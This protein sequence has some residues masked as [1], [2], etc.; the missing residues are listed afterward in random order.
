MEALDQAF[1]L[2]RSRYVVGIDLGTTNCAMA[3][4]D[5][6]DQARRVQTMSI[7]QMIEFGM[8][9]HLDTLPSF[10]YELTESEA[11]SID[12]R[13]RFNTGAQSKEHPG[14]VGALARERSMQVPGRGIASAKSWLCNTQVDRNSDLLPWHGDEEV[15]RL[16]PVE[17]SSRYLLH[18]RRLWDRQHP[19]DPLSEQEVVVTLP[20]SFDEVA[21]QL[22]LEATRRAGLENVVLI[23]E[24]QAA[25]YAWLER[26]Q[27][28]WSETLRP[29][30]TILV[31]DIGGGTTDFTLIRVIDSAIALQA[32]ADASSSAAAQR[33]DASRNVEQKLQKTFGL[34]RVA[35]GPHLLLGG[36][37]LDLA[38][39]H[40]VEQQLAK[41]ANQQPLTPR[42]WDVLKAQ[43]RKAKETMLGA[44]PPDRVTIAL[45]GSGAKLI[46]STR[47]VTIERDW[48]KRL[49]VEGFFGQVPL[50]AVP[51]RGEVLFQEFGLPYESEPSVHK[52]LAQFLWEHRWAGRADS[53]RSNL[54]DRLAARPDWIL[55]NG[56]VLESKEIRDA[57]LLQIR[58][59]F[60]P[61]S[62]SDWSPGELEGN[63]LDL[64][65]AI[66]AAYF[67]LVRR[68]EGIR[69]DARLARTY[70]LQ[71]Q[72]SPPKAICIM[73]ASAM[74]L[75]RL[76]L[77]QHPFAL[78]IGEPV[79]FP[80]YCSST[81]L[82]HAFGEIIDVDLQWMTP[83]P[84][85]QT[86][87]ESGRGRKRETIPV[88]LECE[89]T[90]IGTLAMR[91][92][93]EQRQEGQERAPSWNLE[94]DVR[95][96]SG[97]VGPSA[98]QGSLTETVDDEQ[99]DRGLA[100]L[101]RIF[102]PSPSSPPKE[103]YTLVAEA[104]GVSRRQWPASLLRGMWRY[105]YDH[106][107]SRKRSPDV[108]ARWLN[109]LGWSLRPGFGFPADDWRVQQ[110]WRAVHNKLM[111]RSPSSVSES[112][113][114]WRR[115]A[116]GFTTGQQNALYQDAWSRMRP[117][118]HGGG[119]PM[120][121]NVA[122]ELLRL[123]G[124]LERLRSVDKAGLVDS[125]LTALPKKK[126]DALRPAILWMVGRLGSRVPVYASLQQTVSVDRACGWIDRL[127]AI[128]GLGYGE[129]KS[130]FSLALML[131]ARRTGDRYRDVPESFRARVLDR[132]EAIQ[133]PRVHIDLVERSG[134]AGRR[135]CDS[136]RRGF[137]SSGFLAS[138]V[139][140]VIKWCNAEP[141]MHQRETLASQV[142]G[143]QDRTPSPNPS[144]EHGSNQLAPSPGSRT[145]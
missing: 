28:R 47:T 43:S 11:S 49:L 110:T 96:G 118:F 115:I 26:H 136:D 111:H 119:V 32:E 7:E 132:L 105:L 53:D 48:A 75:D 9:G 95:S 12:S 88:V 122:I 106:A 92:V 10:H 73:P 42:Q 138:V 65:V 58:S 99:V 31:C 107:D 108:E 3:Y 104:T 23:E 69:I 16:S 24:P 78:K 50:D 85:I 56:G 63:R 44:N 61:E 90:E 145:L 38:L 8:L 76:R 124:S 86:V 57:I 82:T 116:G 25:F 34:H 100:A 37:N 19:S 21:R 36:D 123:L 17:A 70:Y 117:M 46:A 1:E 91:V 59:W 5:S 120:N 51:T 109:L 89:L 54:T 135:E 83:L 142:L 144:D 81:Q 20:A 30:Q 114:L 121:A 87:L 72:Q 113:I 4:L 103:A 129:D 22:T 29:G 137:A 79:Q 140:K 139:I 80:I 77:D 2:Q 67:G 66:G 71:V 68:G 52:H 64:A 101:E 97:D 133:A 94:F 41:E 6:Q 39:A 93:S 40:Y 35:V 143:C 18:L 62:G 98:G 130:S 15:E 127:L 60:A 45:P 102:G 112:I 134:L 33:Q 128:E 74:P 84:A 14:I 13:F 55:F 27:D 141:P 125:V 126:M 131:L